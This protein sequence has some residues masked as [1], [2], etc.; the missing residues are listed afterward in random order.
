MLTRDKDYKNWWM[1]IKVIASQPLDIFD[2][3]CRPIIL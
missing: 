1:C 3:H 2:S